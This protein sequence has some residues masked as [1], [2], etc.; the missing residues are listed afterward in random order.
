MD[1]G[2]VIEAAI[3]AVATADI[4]DH[5]RQ[6]QEF[7]PGQSQTCESAA[8][9]L[10]FIGA[11]IRRLLGDAELELFVSSDDEGFPGRKGL[12]IVGIRE[13]GREAATDNGDGFPLSGVE[14]VLADLHDADRRGESGSLES[15]R[16]DFAVVVFV[17]FE[18]GQSLPLRL[19]TFS[20]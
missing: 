1:I 12:P 8:G 11:K 19:G 18:H 3:T 2:I 4:T 15:D 7:G 6:A 17:D 20:R 14:F 16:F 5:R 13:L 9:F 10:S